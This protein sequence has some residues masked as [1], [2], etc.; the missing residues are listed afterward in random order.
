MSAS[1]RYFLS[2]F[3]SLVLLTTM[4]ASSMRD[5]TSAPFSSA[6]RVRSRT[7]S[8]VSLAVM[9]N[10]LTCSGLKMASFV[11]RSRLLDRCEPDWELDPL[12]EA[13][14]GRGRGRRGNPMQIQATTRLP[15]SSWSRRG[16][17]CVSLSRNQ[18][19]PHADPNGA[20]Q[21]RV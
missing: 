12:D 19:R 2:L 1:G 7:S 4:L 9:M 20:G 10:I 6:F 16:R 17:T 18:Y 13:C 15:C 8:G 3:H 14:V 21:E 11:R 5:T